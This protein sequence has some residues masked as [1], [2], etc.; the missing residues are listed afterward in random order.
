MV[1]RDAMVFMVV[2]RDAMVFM[3]VIRDA[4]VFM[5]VIRDAMVFMVYRACSAVTTAADRG[6]I[7]AVMFCVSSRGN[8]I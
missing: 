4:M 6:E 3:V 7:T 2:I 5:V 8:S 1:I